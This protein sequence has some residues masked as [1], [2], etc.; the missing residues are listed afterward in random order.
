[1]TGNIVIPGVDIPL[2]EIGDGTIFINGSCIVGGYIG[3]SS[4]ENLDTVSVTDIDAT[5]VEY[6]DFIS[7]SD[8]YQTSNA[9]SMVNVPL[10]RYY[11]DNDSFY[12]RRVRTETATITARTLYTVNAPTTVSALYGGWI[13][14]KPTFIKLNKTSR[15]VWAASTIEQPFQ[16]VKLKNAIVYSMDTSYS[17]SEAPRADFVVDL[18]N[19]TVEFMFNI[20][21]LYHDGYLRFSSDYE[22]THIF[23]NEK[24]ELFD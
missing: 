24:P 2:A 19:E 21:N 10:I 13:M 15:G 9:S 20:Y 7:N 12:F 16:Y 22:T 8:T 6:Q 4:L 1:M 14:N 3:M 17:F 18:F 5:P 11:L 23:S